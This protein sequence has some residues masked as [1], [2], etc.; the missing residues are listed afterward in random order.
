MYAAVEHCVPSAHTKKIFNWETNSLKNAV[1]LPL[2]GNGLSTALEIC[3]GHKGVGTALRH[4]KVE[5]WQLRKMNKTFYHTIIQTL[6]DPLRLLK[7][8]RNIRSLTASSK[9]SVNL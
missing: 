7:V 5:E 8:V 3:V 9:I 2:F 4:D 1:L 6:K